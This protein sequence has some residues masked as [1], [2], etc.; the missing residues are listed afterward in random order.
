MHKFLLFGMCLALCLVSNTCFG[1]EIHEINLFLKRSIV[2]PDGARPVSWN[3]YGN[4]NDGPKQY[5][6]IPAGQFFIPDIL[7]YSSIPDPIPD[8]VP[9][10]HVRLI[11]SSTVE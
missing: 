4:D 11:L 3:D 5:F 6:P 9:R 2:S 8:P 1:N 10:G 7:H